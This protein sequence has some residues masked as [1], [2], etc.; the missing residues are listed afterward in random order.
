M[1]VIVAVLIVSVVI[2]ALLQM[3]GTT[4]TLFLDIKKRLNTN[5]IVTLTLWNQNYGFEKSDA[6]LYRLVENFNIDDTLRRELK[7]SKIKISYDTLDSFDTQN[8]VLELGK[9]KISSK[10]FSLFIDRV[11]MQ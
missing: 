10:D 8:S 6:T 4:A 7:K 3:R 9:T 2:A 1:E 5:Q 11:R